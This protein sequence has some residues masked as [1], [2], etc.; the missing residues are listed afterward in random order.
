MVP[1]I[2]TEFA[3][4]SGCKPASVPGAVNDTEVAPLKSPPHGNGFPTLL[5]ACARSAGGTSETRTGE[6]PRSYEAL[7]TL[8]PVPG[9]TTVT[10]APKDTLSVFPG[11]A[12]VTITVDEGPSKTK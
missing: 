9:M 6:L 10:V 1:S 7:L 3:W 5:T 2:V 4:P 8:A 12:Q 11:G